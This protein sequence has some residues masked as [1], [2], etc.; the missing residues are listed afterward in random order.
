MSSA[1]PVF[2]LRVAA[3]PSHPF[4]LAPT[5]AMASGPSSVDTTNTVADAP[6]PA[7]TPVWRRAGVRSSETTSVLRG[8]PT[9][10]GSR[11]GPGW[12]ILP[13]T[14]RALPDCRVIG[15]TSSRPRTASAPPPGV[16]FA[17]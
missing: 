2:S 15:E 13:A 11:P 16:Q 1:S 14:M 9:P 10:T 6:A 3:T 8:A 4:G 17:L 7:G 12:A 5:Q